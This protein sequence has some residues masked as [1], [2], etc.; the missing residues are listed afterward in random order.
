MK[1]SE[2]M[3]QRHGKGVSCCQIF[4][5]TGHF[6]HPIRDGKLGSVGHAYESQHSAGRG[7]QISV[8]SGPA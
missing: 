6:P 8:C 4:P 7:R 1:D 5:G 3:R 2:P